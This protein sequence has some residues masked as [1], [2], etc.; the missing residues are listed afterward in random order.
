MATE[1]GLTEAHGHMLPDEK[2]SYLKKMQADGK[3]VAFVGDGVNDSPSLALADIGIAMG[4][5]T[6]VAIET[7]DIVLM[8][9]DFSRLPHALGLAKAIS[10]NMQQNIA[11][12]IGVV[13]IL[14]GSVLFGDWMT[15]SIG[16]VVHEASILVV[17]LNGM[18][19]LRYR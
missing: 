8:N 4:R 5:G 18:R 13:L 7:S 19:L 2:P 12:A 15:M 9:S 14:L 11:I 17:I 6:D 10:R 1:L 3:I 16:M